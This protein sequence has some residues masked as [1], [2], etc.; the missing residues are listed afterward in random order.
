MVKTVLSQIFRVVFSLFFSLC[1][2]G[3]LNR[4][5]SFQQV[6]LSQVISLHVVAKAVITFPCAAPGQNI[7]PGVTFILSLVIIRRLDIR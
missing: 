6:S 5:I 2:T 4:G 1:L 7:L 3:S